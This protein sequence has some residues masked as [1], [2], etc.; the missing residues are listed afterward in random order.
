M[1]G[2]I[3]AGIDMGSRTC[4]TVLMAPK[5][6]I[7]GYSI[8]DTGA[9]PQ[10]AGMRSLKQAL[11]HCLC[12]PEDIVNLVT[13]GYG[14]HRLSIAKA[15]ITEISCHAKGAH[16]LFPKTRTI[17]DIGGQDSKVIVID[18]KG[19]V[20]DFVM[21][22]KCAAGTGRFLEVMAMA[23]E[24]GIAEMGKLS[25][26]ARRSAPINSLCTVFAESEV[27]SLIASGTQKEEIIRGLH[28]SISK[29]IV[30]MAKGLNIE[31]EITLSGGVAKNMGIVD[32]MERLLGVKI[33]IPQEPQIVGAIGAALFAM[34]LHKKGG[35]RWH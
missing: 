12:D 6:D 15:T 24:V 18:E 10:G 9:D 28:E 7:V 30:R 31:A 11:S 13:T 17:I 2:P 8:V 22:D 21:N 3:Y 33:N 20:L 35:K 25:I 14:R 16:F 19:K 1:N 5:R 27:I 23:L 26:T 4:K 29:R 32:S 34:N